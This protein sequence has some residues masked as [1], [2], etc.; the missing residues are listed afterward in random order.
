MFYVLFFSLS[1]ISWKA[2]STPLGNARL[3]FSCCMLLWPLPLVASLPCCN[4]LDPNLV[5]EFYAEQNVRHPQKL[6]PWSFSICF[7]RRHHYFAHVGNLSRRNFCSP[8]KSVLCYARTNRSSW[9]TKHFSAHST[10]N[11]TPTMVTDPLYRTVRNKCTFGSYE[12]NVQ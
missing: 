4:I 10:S 9:V 5:S 3:I 12:V 2:F 7:L 6:C 8:N 1:T 11:N